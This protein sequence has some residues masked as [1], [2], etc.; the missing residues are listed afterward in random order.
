MT[1]LGVRRRKAALSRAA[2]QPLQPGATG[3]VME[4]TKWL[5]PLVSVSRIGDSA[6][7]QAVTRV[8]AV[9]S[10]KRTMRRSARQPFRGKA[11]KAKECAQLGPR[12]VRVNFHRRG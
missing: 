7:M 2:R 12:A 10:S 9:Q 8:N 5:R 11:D 3:A 1:G 4:A 6:S